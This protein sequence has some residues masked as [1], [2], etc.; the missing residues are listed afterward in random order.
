[1][2][3]ML[4]N[5]TVKKLVLDLEK[6]VEAH[7][8]EPNNL[9]FLKKLLAKAESEDEAIS[10]C[11]LGTTYYRTGL[12]FDKKLEVPSDGLRIF[13]KNEKL[14]FD[15]GGLK[16]TLIIGDNYDALLN[17]LVE[18][19]GK[20][21]AIYID[22]PYGANTMGEFAETNYANQ[23]NR[24][25]LL[26][27]LQPR[28][29]LAR[30]LLSPRGVIFCSIDDK[31][32]AYLKCLF[33][34]IFE[35]K[36]FISCSA[37]ETNRGGRDY[38]GIAL[39]H[40][41]LL[42][43]CND[44]MEA[45]LNPI[46]DPGRKFKYKDENGGFD[47]MEL[48]NRNIKFNIG[49]RP[50]LCY[51]FYLNPNTKD[52]NGLFK[53]SLEKTDDFC[54]EVIPAKSQGVQ[55]VWRWGKDKALANLNVEIF[56][57]E[58]QNGGYMIVEKYRKQT[59]MQRSIWDDK[60]FV[61]EVGTESVKKIFGKAMFDYPKSPKLIRRVL[62]LSTKEDSVV[63]DFFA[64][65]GTTAQ[66]VLD[67]NK[68]DGGKRKFIL[69]QLPENLESD[70]KNQTVLNQ[71]EL[72]DSYGLPRNLAYVTADRI[73]RIMLGQGYDGRKDFDWIKEN[74]A[75]GNSLDVYDI[76]EYSVYDPSVFKKI[77][78][79]YYGLPKFENIRDKIEWV[80]KNFEKVARKISD[81]S[82]N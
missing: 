26:S 79:E 65:S 27:M 29:M 52:K 67:L 10:I 33:D 56:G 54:I 43:Y 2:G 7:I 76:E 36:N 30:Q 73:R 40:E 51:P 77:H 78:E 6:R 24:D 8:L 31:N 28:L 13:E 21:D 38:G 14:S 81:A 70:S 69:V 34:Q 63:L 42:I 35:E 15:Q 16:N 12:I 64:G 75:Y 4:E 66:A 68:T 18:F 37:I 55:T 59:R 41:Y 58:N 82:G 9:E 48:R 60:D 1:M 62:E 32:C 45:E 61:H 17:L 5:E 50:N 57:K 47:L 39:Q 22:P 3:T 23:I 53:L 19:R 72:L 80:C 46:S 25:N 49:N 74:E 44:T 71:I 11:K 20:I